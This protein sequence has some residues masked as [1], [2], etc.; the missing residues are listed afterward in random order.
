MHSVD[1]K[2]RYCFKLRN[3]NTSYRRCHTLKGFRLLL[4]DPHP[5]LRDGRVP[6]DTSSSCQF[7]CSRTDYNREWGFIYS[8]WIKSRCNSPTSILLPQEVWNIS[9]W[10][11][12]TAPGVD[13]TSSYGAYKAPIPLTAN[14]CNRTHRQSRK[15]W[16]NRTLTVNWR[17]AWNPIQS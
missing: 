16:Q 15:D 3:T 2:R 13:Y 12:A 5:M 11:Q 4:S 6:D 1:C 7:L 14:T 17:A 8:H 9:S 10:S